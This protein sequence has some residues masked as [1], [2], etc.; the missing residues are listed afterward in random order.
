MVEDGGWK[1]KQGEFLVKSERVIPLRLPSQM[2]RE[3]TKDK[4]EV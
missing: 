4:D 1:K 2:L 3:A